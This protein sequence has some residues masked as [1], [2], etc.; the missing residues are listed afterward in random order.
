[1]A[2]EWRKSVTQNEDSIQDKTW[3][4][5]RLVEKN[6]ELRASPPGVESPAVLAH[7]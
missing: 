7:S 2:S 3:E 1:M 6:E 4:I 5:K